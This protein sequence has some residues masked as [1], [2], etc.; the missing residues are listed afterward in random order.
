MLT[1]AEAIE[2]ACTIVHRE[3]EAAEKKAAEKGQGTDQAKLA[4]RRWAEW[5]EVETILRNVK[6]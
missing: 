4:W 5:K 3:V 6:K 1:K 2:R